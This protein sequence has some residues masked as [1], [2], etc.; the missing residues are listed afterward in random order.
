MFIYWKR[1]TAPSS[2]SARSARH[3]LGRSRDL[4][5]HWISSR[6]QLWRRFSMMR[7]VCTTIRTPSLIPTQRM[8]QLASSIALERQV[9]SMSMSP[10]THANSPYRHAKAGVSHQRL[11]HDFRFYFSSRKA[12]RSSA[13]YVPRS[14]SNW[15]GADY[16]TFLSSNGTGCTCVLGVVRSSHPC[17][18]R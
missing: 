18:P 12:G 5:R 10:W 6:S 2:F 9:N 16:D 1:Q 3:E 7:V 11:L 4:F 13:I 15:A 14:G 8:T 17:W